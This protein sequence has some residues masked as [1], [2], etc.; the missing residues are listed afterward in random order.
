[1]NK[2]VE[3]DLEVT[4]R[5]IDKNKKIEI[6]VENEGYVNFVNMKLKGDLID[7]QL[8]RLQSVKLRNADKDSMVVDAHMTLKIKKSNWKKGWLVA[9]ALVVVIGLVGLFASMYECEE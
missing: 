1:M 7:G 9:G 5:E 6:V 2:I 8:L 4:Q 3:F